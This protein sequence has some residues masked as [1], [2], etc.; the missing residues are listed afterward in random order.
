MENK[1]VEL[2]I[3]VETLKRGLIEMFD[4]LEK[5]RDYGSMTGAEWV[6]ETIEAVLS[7]YEGLC[8]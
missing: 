1:N 4:T 3:E 8:S 7:K 2:E 6:S 5:V